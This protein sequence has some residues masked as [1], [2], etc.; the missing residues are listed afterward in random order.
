MAL[1]VYT[2]GR[3]VSTCTLRGCLGS[4]APASVKQS[5]LSPPP[6]LS[7]SCPFVVFLSPVH[8]CFVALFIPWRTTFQRYWFWMTF[9]GYSP[10]WW[11][12]HGRQSTRWMVTLSTDVERRGEGWCSLL[13]LLFFQFRDPACVLVLPPFL[14]GLRLSRNT[15]TGMPRNLSPKGV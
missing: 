9:R 14:C 2:G 1:S 6:P 4:Q 13:F 3:Q 11:R 10:S 8:F 7:F 15:L 5:S 12:R